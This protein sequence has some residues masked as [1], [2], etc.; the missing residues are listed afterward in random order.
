MES[1]LAEAEKQREV[2]EREL[3][4]KLDE[5]AAML[6]DMGFENTQANVDALNSCGGDL[7]TA[8]EYLISASG[9]PG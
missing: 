4:S 3:R 8:V 7:Q 5:Q 9:G 6:V 1:E 2:K